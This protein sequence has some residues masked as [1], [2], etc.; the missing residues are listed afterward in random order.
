MTRRLRWQD[1]A[2][3][4][5][6][7]VEA[8]PSPL[9]G[10]GDVVP[11]VHT[12]DGEYISAELETWAEA[13]TVFADDAPVGTIEATGTTTDSESPWSAGQRDQVLDQ[14]ALLTIRTA[15][16]VAVSP[17]SHIADDGQTLILVQGETYLAAI[18]NALLINITDPR[19]PDPIEGTVPVLRIAAR[20]R[21]GAALSVEGVV[22]TFDPETGQAVAGFE[23]TQAQSAGLNAGTGNVW[24]LD[25]KI[26]GDATQVITS[27]IDAPCHVRRQIG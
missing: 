3:R 8:R 14:L 17:G 24:E 25:W 1:E 12:A 26:S 6:L 20:G 7:A 21:V 22:T 5:D 13:Y 18:D 27:V 9:D 2:M 16:G 23:M 4:P 15:A 19:L 10:E 11:L